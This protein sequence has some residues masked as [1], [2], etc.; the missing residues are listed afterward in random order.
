VSAATAGT[1]PSAP[2]V[3]DR[4]LLLSVLCWGWLA[5]GSEALS[6]AGALRRGPVLLWWAV[7]AVV[8]LV[9]LRRWRSGAPKAEALRAPDRVLVAAVAVLLGTALVQALV[10]PPNNSDSLTYHLPRQVYWAQSG[11]LDHYPT[12]ELRQ[13]TMPPLAE[14]AGLHLLVATGSDRWHNLVQWSALALAA[15]AASLLARE[16]GGGRFAQLLAAVLVVSVP[17]ALAQASN[18]KNDDVVA[19]WLVSGTL[20][21]F[22]LWRA[23]PWPSREW[24]PAVFGICLGGLLLTKGTGLVFAL[25]LAALAACP[26]LR[27]RVVPVSLC[28]L[29]AAGLNA[30]HVGRNWRAFGSAY[31]SQRDA[32]GERLASELHT[33]AALVSIASR[34]L[35]RQLVLPLAGWN[36]ALQGAVE[37]L[38][39]VLGLSPDDPRT[40]FRPPPWGRLVYS[41]GSED[42]T[43]APVHVLLLILLP[44]VAAVV[45]A[46]GDGAIRGALAAWALTVLAFLVFSAAFKWQLWH[47]RLLIPLFALGAAPLAVVL[48]VRPGLALLATLAAVVSAAPTAAILQRPLLGERSIL[49]ADR[50]SL[51]FHAVPGMAGPGRQVLQMLGTLEPRVVGLDADYSYAWMGGL[52]TVTGRWPRFTSFNARFNPARAPEPRP[53]VLVLS[54]RPPAQLRHESSGE[55]YVPIVAVGPVSLAVPEGEALGALTRLR[56]AAASEG[57]P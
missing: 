26:L 24:L 41:G 29:L 30:P 46:R 45:R 19:F 48:A 42:A 15:V 7:G 8:A 55:V 27:C 10:C 40:T 37:S 9:W 57:A 13:L 6:A 18:T 36:A 22:R 32:H 11:R 39:G 38:H 43:N 47:G 49:G 54:S 21:A 34:N 35:A 4:L 31:G 53:D 51:Y 20:Y 23:A 28:L 12:S 25:P 14:Y 50:A 2:G 5:V 33:P 52:A 1:A 56:A 16:L 44:I 3:R 17:P